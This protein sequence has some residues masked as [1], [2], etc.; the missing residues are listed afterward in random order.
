[1]AKK[2]EERSGVALPMVGTVTGWKV[3]SSGI[4]NVVKV[5]RKAATARTLLVFNY[6]SF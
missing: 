5:E 6:T 3:L 1:M 2:A 4:T